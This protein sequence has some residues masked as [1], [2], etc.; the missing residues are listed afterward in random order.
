[1]TAKTYRCKNRM[2]AE[3]GGDVSREGFIRFAVRRGAGVGKNNGVRAWIEKDRTILA[4][5]ML[6]D[7][8]LRS[9]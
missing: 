4:R 9:G 3:T 6:R 5:G 8:S 2:T 1:M 7:P